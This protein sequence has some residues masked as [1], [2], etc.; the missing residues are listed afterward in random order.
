MGYPKNHSFR[1]ENLIERQLKKLLA[2]NII[3]FLVKIIWQEN[4]DAVLIGYIHC[5]LL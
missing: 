3:T 5:T 2:H 4:I 1:K